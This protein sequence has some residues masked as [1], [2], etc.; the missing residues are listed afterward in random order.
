MSLKLSFHIVV[1]QSFSN[2]PL[3]NDLGLLRVKRQISF[4][5]LS[6][7]YNGFCRWSQVLSRNSLSDGLQGQHLSYR[8]MTFDV[9]DILICT[10][11]PVHV[12]PYSAL[13]THIQRLST[14]TVADIEYLRTGKGAVKR[15]S[16]SAFLVV[17]D[18]ESPACARL[19]LITLASGRHSL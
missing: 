3:P 16:G 10:T 4:T 17:I 6:V 15:I 7:S 12:L 5:Y 2:T 11:H 13:P 14:T 19:R 18:R 9:V 1:K 8:G